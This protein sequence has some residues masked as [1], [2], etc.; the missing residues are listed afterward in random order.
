MTN[1]MAEEWLTVAV[2]ELRDA[3]PD[4]VATAAETV[5]RTC[6][7]HGQIIPTMIVEIEKLRQ[8]QATRTRQ[9]AAWEPRVALPASE[10]WRPTREELDALKR[11]A[12]NSLRADR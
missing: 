4:M 1:D 12:S 3:D 5:R 8:E 11:A 7:H 6:T 9:E 2:R 10:P